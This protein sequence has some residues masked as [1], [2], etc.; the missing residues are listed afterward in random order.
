MEPKSRRSQGEPRPA[1]FAGSTQ[2]GQHLD[3]RGRSHS[4][5]SKDRQPNDLEWL[6]SHLAHGTRASI[7]VAPAHPVPPYRTLLFNTHLPG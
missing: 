3:E 4:G 1:Q 6:D 7:P 2:A 5:G